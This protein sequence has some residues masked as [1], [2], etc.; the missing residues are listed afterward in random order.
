MFTEDQK[1]IHEGLKEIGEEISNFYSD[2]LQIFEEKCAIASKANLVAH[3]A[4]EIDGGIRDV[5]APDIIKQEVIKEAPGLEEKK[6]FISIL[7]TLGRTKDD[8]LANEWFSIAS[9]FA[10]IV[11]RHGAWKKTKPTGEIMALWK[12]YE[13]VLF[14]LVGSFYRIIDRLEHIS[15]LAEPTPEIMGTLFNILKNPKY[16]FHFFTRLAQLKWIPH[17]NDAGYF[18]PDNASKKNENDVY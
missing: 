2:A 11:H 7:A 15:K 8:K 13:K 6:H 16:E 4:R 10:D 5:F 3:L 14:A 9:K 12:R 1:R 17:L 18:N